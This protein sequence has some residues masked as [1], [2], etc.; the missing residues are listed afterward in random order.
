MN[1]D[2]PTEKSTGPLVCHNGTEGAAAAEG[3]AAPPLA[4]ML[5]RHLIRDG[6]LIL[7]TLKPSIWYILFTSLRFCAVVLMVMIGVELL[8]Y[9]TPYRA[10]VFIEVGILMIAGR[11]MW[12]VLMWMSRL[13]ILTDM[14]ILILSGVFNAEIFDCPLRKIARTRI[15]RTMKDRPLNLGSIEIIPLD[16]NLPI[17]M[18]QTISNPK[19][20]HQ[21]VLAAISRAKQGPSI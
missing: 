9:Q 16:E 18:W 13:Y 10:R 14:R 11:V 7:L 19:H 20:I 2:R 4:T 6:E 17:G 5:T 21:Q 12:A 3:V 15:V 1:P 8:E